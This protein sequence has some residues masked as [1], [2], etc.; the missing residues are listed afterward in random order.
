M[1]TDMSTTP[2]AYIG[3]G[4]NDGL[5][6]VSEKKDNAVGS[7]AMSSGELKIT[8][9]MKGSCRAVLGTWICPTAR[10][11]LADQARRASPYPLQRPRIHERSRFRSV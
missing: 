1:S 2:D 3:D 4:S 10:C 8:E 7:G 6:P 9:P 5:S 11:W